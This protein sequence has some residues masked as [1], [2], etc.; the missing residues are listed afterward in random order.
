MKQSYIEAR[1][2]GCSS[3]FEEWRRFLLLAII[4]L[5]ILAVCA[6]GAY[7]FFVWFMQLLFW[8]PPS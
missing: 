5:P 7:G 1:S 8:G 2:K 4:I 3:K 6:I